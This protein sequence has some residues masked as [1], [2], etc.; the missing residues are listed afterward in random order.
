[1]A[2]QLVDVAVIG[3]GLAGLAAAARLSSSQRVAVLEAETKLGGQCRSEAIPGGALDLGVHGIYPRYTELKALLREAGA[4]LTTLIR[5]HRQHVMTPDGII[6]PVR[7]PPIPAPLNGLV[8]VALLTGADPIQRLCA[9]TS[10]ARMLALSTRTPALGDF[11]IQD[12]ALRCGMPIGAFRLVLEPLAWVG[13]FL[14]PRQIAADAY[15]SA[16]RF[17]VI[18]RTD[19]WHASWVRS[20]NGDTL[21]APV[22][23][24]CAI[25]GGQ[26]R[27]G[28]RAT[29]LLSNGVR[30][31]GV[32]YLDQRGA[33]HEITCRAVVCAVQPGAAA[34]LIST[35]PGAAAA[36]EARSLR[37]LGQTCVRT[38]RF[39]FERGPSPRAGHGIA[40][41]S[42]AGF[43]FLSLGD[44]MPSMRHR[45]VIEIQYAPDIVGEAEDELLMHLRRLL[46]D[47]DQA[48]LLDIVGTE[49]TTYARYGLESGTF[50]PN[51]QS[52]WVGLHFAGDWVNDPSG[53]WFMERAVRTG[54]GAANAILGLH[55]R[56]VSSHIEGP[57]VRATQKLLGRSVRAL[58]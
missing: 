10:L 29:A 5:S 48:K 25:H 27:T 4:P 13:F 55:P 22:A 31:T 9:A 2:T 43:A 47:G 8:H 45:R 33:A 32:R 58:S 19:S 18:G 23:R 17:L 41:T 6:S 24:L 16:L 34:G 51:V 21:V 7:M 3:G 39:E 40:L 30:I 35:I 50:R 36:Q 1:M 11:S 12:F 44:M 15:L 56:P 14:S 28:C 37:S 52:R 57:L 49:I 53:A 46:P 26:I 38:L 20:P 42:D 54:R